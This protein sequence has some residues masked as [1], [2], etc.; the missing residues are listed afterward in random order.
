M[1]IPGVVLTGLLLVSVPVSG[2]TPQAQRPGAVRIAVHDPTDLSVAGAEVTLTASDGS[3]MR[4]STNDRGEASF[5]GIRPGVYSG[6]VEW[7]GFNPFAIEQFTIRAGARVTR[8]VTLQVA[9][10]V[11]ELNVTP[12]ADDQ[13]LMNSFVRQLTADEVAALPEDPEELA[14]VLQQLLGD[15]ADIR[16]DG[17]SGG[18]LPLG[19]Q[20]QEVRI[21]YDLGVRACLE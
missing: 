3:T 13:Q 21:R 20:I 11:E 17:F 19:T 10:F 9:G 7:V 5:E 14:L 15:D 1:R 16:V 12:A 8:Q 4:A 18:R 6:R 2:Q